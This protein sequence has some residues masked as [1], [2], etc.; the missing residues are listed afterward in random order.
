MSSS[1]QYWSVI[2]QASTRSSGERGTGAD[3]G[4][5]DST[6]FGPPNGTLTCCPA[7]KLWVC[8]LDEIW[9]EPLNSLI[10]ISSFLTAARLAFPNSVIS[11][12]LTVNLIP[13]PSGME[14]MI[15]SNGTSS[16]I[17]SPN[18]LEK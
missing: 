5:I 10:F 17:S 9:P 14:S 15:P 16:Q 7:P 13:V 12:P 8:P 2:V 18:P 3:G 6:P 4:P 11:A 1:E